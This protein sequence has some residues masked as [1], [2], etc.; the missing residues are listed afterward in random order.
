MSAHARLTRF[1]NGEVHHLLQDRGLLIKMPPSW[2]EL[3]ARGRTL[4][5]ADVAREAVARRLGVDERRWE[6]IELACSVGVVPLGV[7][8][9]LPLSTRRSGISQTD[10]TK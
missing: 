2:R 9:I 4:Q 5:G 8:E 1:A 6:E 7:G 3:H 10:S